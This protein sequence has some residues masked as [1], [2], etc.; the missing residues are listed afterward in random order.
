MTD[1][2]VYFINL[3]YNK[4]TEAVYRL[5]YDFNKYAYPTGYFDGGYE[6]I[7]G[8]CDDESVYRNLI[9]TCGAR[10]VEEMNLGVSFL[11][12]GEDCLEIYV[13][14]ENNPEISKPLRPYGTKST[15]P[16]TITNLYTSSINS[17]G[18][19]L[20]YMWEWGDGNMSEWLG[21]FDSG[22]KATASHEWSNEQKYD[23]KVKAKN[24]EGQESPW[25]EPLKINV[26]EKNKD[27]ASNMFIQ[28]FL[29]RN[30]LLFSILRL[31]LRL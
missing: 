21:P 4:V 15:N 9:E 18:E 2:I 1:N 20:Y 13:G 16:N 7:K 10:E 23:I 30:P 25:S 31:I 12:L 3:I 29:E 8:A 6:L 28:K 14:I 17:N 11:Y 22:A 24:A 26:G 19:Q 27:K 5:A